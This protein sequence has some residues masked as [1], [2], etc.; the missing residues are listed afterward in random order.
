MN[1]GSGFMSAKKTYATGIND[2][3]QVTGWDKNSA[4]SQVGDTFIWQSGVGYTNI[5]D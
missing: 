2:N 4:V 3:G 5:G 1:I